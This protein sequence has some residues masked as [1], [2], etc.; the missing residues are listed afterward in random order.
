MISN[1]LK[2]S[3]IVEA[4]SLF[5]SVVAFLLAGRGDELWHW[6]APPPTSALAIKEVVPTAHR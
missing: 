3:E 2:C 5:V 6:R 4:A 1:D